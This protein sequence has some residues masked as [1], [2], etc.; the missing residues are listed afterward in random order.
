MRK[1]AA[2]PP[3]ATAPSGEGVPDADELFEAGAPT[4]VATH[5]GIERGQGPTSS[6]GLNAFHEG[7]TRE[8]KE[9]MAALAALEVGLQENRRGASG[10][11]TPRE[12]PARSTPVRSQPAAMPPIAEVSFGEEMPHLRRA[13]AVRRPGLPRLVVACAV[14]AL[15]LA[16]AGPALLRVRRLHAPQAHLTSDPS[17]R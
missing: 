12:A 15:A 9:M 5:P 13:R 3:S 1:G 14:L 16:A 17:R 10:L 7:P 2:R 11:A 6:S 4:R 8:S